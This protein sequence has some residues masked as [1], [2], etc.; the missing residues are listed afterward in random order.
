MTI[1]SGSASAISSPVTWYGAKIRRRASASSSLPIDTQ[2][3]VTTTSAPS[4]A[5]RG[6]VDGVD[7]AAGRRRR[8]ARARSNI[9]GAGR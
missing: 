9:S 2:V 4:T 3:S 6:S 8:S 5:V 1:A 7:G